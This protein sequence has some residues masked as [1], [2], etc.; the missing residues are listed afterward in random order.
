MARESFEKL[1]AAF[2]HTCCQIHEQIVRCA[3]DYSKD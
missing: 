1:A 3:V 2:Q